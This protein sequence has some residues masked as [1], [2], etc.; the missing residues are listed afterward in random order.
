M[1]LYLMNRFLTIFF[2]ADSKDDKN[3]H[4]CTLR[5]NMASSGHR[6]DPIIDMQWLIAFLLA[7]PGVN[8]VFDGDH[9]LD[10]EAEDLKEIME[11][12]R[13]NPEWYQRWP[14]FES[15]ELPSRTRWRPGYV[16]LLLGVIFVV[17]D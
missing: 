1:P 8:I 13:S 6:I 5:A 16:E 3:D 2:P 10:W 12:V 14:T 4:I 7:H 17:R 11:I 15:I 9:V